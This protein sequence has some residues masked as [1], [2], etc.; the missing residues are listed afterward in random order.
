MKENDFVFEL[1]VPREN[2]YLHMFC[3][4]HNIFWFCSELEM[5]A[6]RCFSCVQKFK[7]KWKQTGIHETDLFVLSLDSKIE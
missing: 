7:G 6:V 4:G 1:G 3:L 2:S 5:D